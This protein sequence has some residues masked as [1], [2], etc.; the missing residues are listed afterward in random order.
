LKEISARDNQAGL[1]SE[2]SRVFGE[3]RDAIAFE[4]VDGVFDELN[5]VALG[6]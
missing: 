5:H 4:E 1:T 3:E 2:G 6:Q